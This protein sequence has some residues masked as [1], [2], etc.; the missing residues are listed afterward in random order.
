MR[1]RT[2]AVLAAALLLPAATPSALAQGAG[3][4]TVYMVSYIEVVPSATRQMTGLLKEL[5]GPS[6]KD[7]GMLRFDVLQRTSPTSEFAIYSVW[8][9]QQALTAHT[10]AAHEKQFRDKV[11]ASLIAPIDDRL[12]VP[13]NAGAEGPP[14][15]TAGAAFV[16]TH[17][18]IGGPNPQNMDAFL[19]V[20]KAFGDTSRKTAGNLRYD[21][22]QQ[23]SRTNHF[24][25]FEVWKNAKAADDYSASA[26]SKD[27]RAKFAPVAGALYDRRVYKAL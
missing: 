12:C 14:S 25:V 18:D 20:L 16:M 10:A 17:V 9:D 7:A 15:A 22:V 6:R 19:P 3:D 24:Q 2:L 8:K 4:P 13:L 21:V 1:P 5:A 26:Q 27:Y 23:K 11:Q